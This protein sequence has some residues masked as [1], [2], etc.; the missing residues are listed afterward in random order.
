MWFYNSSGTA[1]VYFNSINI[2]GT[3]AAANT[4]YSVAF[5]KEGAGTVDTRDN[6]FS[7]LRANGAGGSGYNMAYFAVDNTN[8]TSDYNDLY[9]SDPTT[10]GAWSGFAYDFA[11]YQIVSGKEGNS[12]SVDPLF[13]SN[14]DLHT[15]KPELNNAGVLIPGITTDYSGATRRALGYPGARG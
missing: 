2:A 5:Q 10:V 1:T 7:N 12:V 4:R 14:T 3:A 6:I 13:V 8:I 11:N 9:T 15:T